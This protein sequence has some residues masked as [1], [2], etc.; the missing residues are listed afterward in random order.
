MQTEAEIRSGKFASDEKRRK[1]AMSNLNLKNVK[2]DTKGYLS[3]K[4]YL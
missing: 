1:Q 4:E 2:I 3:Y